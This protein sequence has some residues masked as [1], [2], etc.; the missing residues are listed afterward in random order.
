MKVLLGALLALTLLAAPAQASS[1][2][3]VDDGHHVTARGA[4]RPDDRFR[5]GS[6]TKT[7]TAAVVLQLAAEGRLSLED[8]VDRYVPGVP[9]VPLRE[10]LNHTSGLYDHAADPRVLADWRTHQWRPSELVAI[11]LSHPRVDG[12]HYS[13]T[14]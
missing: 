14:N 3:L 5:V 1:I 6:V 10:L 8:T 11:A 9:A 7:F 13:N 2:V 4:I 12:F